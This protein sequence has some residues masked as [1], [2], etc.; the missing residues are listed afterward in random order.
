MSVLEIACW[1]Q[2]CAQWGTIQQSAAYTT[3]KGLPFVVCR[4]GVKQS[5]AAAVQAAQQVSLSVNG[6]KLQIMAWQG[7]MAKAMAARVNP[8]GLQTTPNPLALNA[9]PAR[10]AVSPSRPASH[11]LHGIAKD[12]PAQLSRAGALTSHPSS[13][14]AA[15]GSAPQSL[16]QGLMHSAAGSLADKRPAAQD[17]AGQPAGFNGAVSSGRQAVW[18]VTHVTGPG[19]LAHAMAWILYNCIFRSHAAGDEAAGLGQRL[20]SALVSLQVTHPDCQL[21]ES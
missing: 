9:R 11:P 12:S 8:H 14:H 13:R 10:H 4:Y 17:G 7:P 18:Q 15:V 5:A 2:A 20:R 6:I 21:L 3:D 1:P 16:H 19:P